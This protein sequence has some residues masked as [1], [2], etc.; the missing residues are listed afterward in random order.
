VII[1]SCGDNTK[2]FEHFIKWGFDGGHAYEN[3]SNVD[4]YEQKKRHGDR[5]TIVGGV[6]VDYLLTERSKPHEVEE[7]VKTL[8]RALAPGGRFI[9]GPVH[10]HPD[11]DISKVKIM[12][13]TVREHGNYPIT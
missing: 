8:I 9:I 12:V 2:M 11:M 5:F 7:G 13:E 4:I 6:G 1:H 10:T 3:T